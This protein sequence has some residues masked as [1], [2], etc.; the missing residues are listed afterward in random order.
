ML[1]PP[2]DEF[3]RKENLAYVRIGRHLHRM[4]VSV[5]EIYRFDLD[6]GWVL[7]ED[8]GETSL[9]DMVH[10]GNDPL[11]LYE[12]AAE[13]LF[14]LQTE[15]VKGFDRRWCCQTEQYDRT[16]IRQYEAN[17]F[18]DAFLSRYLGLKRDWPELEGPFDHLGSMASRLGNHFLLHR[19][20][21]SRNIMVRDG[22]IGILDWQGSRLGPL[23]YD[24]ASLVID[25]YVTLQSS[26][27][28]HILQAYLTLVKKHHLGLLDTFQRTFPYIAIQRN[29]Q[30][31]GAFSYLSQLEGKGYF[32]D[33]IPAALTTLEG[34]LEG[35]NDPELGLLAQA[36]R[37]AQAA[38]KPHGEIARQPNL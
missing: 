21:Q 23:A 25:P 14:R 37:D 17:Y 4:G 33:Y 35:L 6:H 1:N 30:I 15:G 24:V 3:A 9:Q 29:L 36:V 7:M 16:V 38:M 18:R 5:P 19:D 8:L 12:H 31:L 34:L 26:A 20:F 11:P 22:P 27:R 28:D 13:Q 2:H 32:Q 10:A